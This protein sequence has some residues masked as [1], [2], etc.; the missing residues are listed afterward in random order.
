MHAMWAEWAPPLERSKLV[1]LS[2]AGAQFGTVIGLPLAGVITD[3]L[4]WEYVFY[5]FGESV[6]VSWRYEF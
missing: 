1:T 3:Y 6:N 5:I 2:Y 4:G